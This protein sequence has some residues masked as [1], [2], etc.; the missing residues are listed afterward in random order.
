MKGCVGAQLIMHPLHHF[1]K[2]LGV[3]V[4]P[5]DGQESD[6]LMTPAAGNGNQG[7]LHRGKGAARVHAVKV[8]VESFQ[9]GIERM[10]Y[11]Q[12]LPEGPTADIAIGYHHI[13]HTGLCHQAGRVEHELKPNSGFVVSIGQPN[14]KRLEGGLKQTL[15]RI[16]RK[17]RK[18]VAVGL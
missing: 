18:A 7:L 6:L 2:M 15:W 12:Q 5:R 11:L 17:L 14:A 10:G 13:F 16:G 1:K 3:V 4:Q 8:V 9:V